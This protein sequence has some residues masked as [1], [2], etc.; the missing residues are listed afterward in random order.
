MRNNQIHGKNL[1]IF[2]HYSAPL[3][4]E[5]LPPILI[6]P[7][8]L[9]FRIRLIFWVIIV[10]TSTHSEMTFGVILLLVFRCNGLLKWAKLKNWAN[11]GKLTS[12]FEISFFAENKCLL[13]FFL[14]SYIHEATKCGMRAINNIFSIFLFMPWLSQFWRPNSHL[15]ISNTYSV[16]KLHGLARSG[17]I[18]FQK[19]MFFANEWGMRQ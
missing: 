16:K 19:L 8:I 4:D 14:L 5:V 12:I 15:H 2:C 7:K 13:Y 1:C 11:L 18:W 17:T 6:R 10:N 3:C 9:V